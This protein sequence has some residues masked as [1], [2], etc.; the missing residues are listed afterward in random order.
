MLDGLFA[1]LERAPGQ[2]SIR[3]TSVGA[4]SSIATVVG[5]PDPVMRM[6]ANTRATV[7]MRQKHASCSVFWNFSSISEHIKVW[8][9]NE[10]SAMTHS[11]ATT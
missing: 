6:L 3:D 11:V 8:S 5:L 10:T 7:L 1:R 4:L 9:G 2:D